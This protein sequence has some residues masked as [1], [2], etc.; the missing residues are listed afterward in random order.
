MDLPW[1]GRCTGATMWVWLAVGC[2]TSPTLDTH[3]KP[4]GDTGTTGHITGADALTLRHL[5]DLHG[6]LAPAFV[7][8]SVEH[9]ELSARTSD[10]KPL[11][12]VNVPFGGLPMLHP[13]LNGAAEGDDF[14]IHTG[15]AIAQTPAEGAFPM[16]TV[17]RATAELCLDVFVPGE[18]EL[19]GPGLEAMLE[20]LGAAP[21]LTAPLGS[22]ASERLGTTAVR[23]LST[24]TWEGRTELDRVG[25][26]G[27]AQPPA[28]ITVE[29]ATEFAQTAIDTLAADG[30]RNIVVVSHLGYSA[31]VALAGALHG[32][33]V[34]VGGHSHTLLGRPETLEPLGFASAGPYPTQVENADGEQVCIAHA[35]EHGHLIGELQVELHE[36]GHV[37]EC[38]GRVLVPVDPSGVTFPDVVG[39][40]AVTVPLPSE[41]VPIVAEA[42][43][44]PGVEVVTPDATLQALLSAP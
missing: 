28:G 34:V 22:H 32:V 14:S 8:V 17:V 18:E 35:W 12:V 23:D 9:L 26:V 27:V 1:P 30:L 6:Q 37:T 16:D 29:Q 15:D 40:E 5:G 20:G 2:A 4:T 13:L 39:G 24:T 3:T 11:Q 33:D 41:D 36:D 21:C 43:S 44:I 10:G 25:F 7:A 38:R 42:L 19:G 31:D